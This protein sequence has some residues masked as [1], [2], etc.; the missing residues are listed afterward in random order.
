GPTLFL[1]GSPVLVSSVTGAPVVLGDPARITTTVGFEEA[2]G[3][4][5][6]A[7]GN[8]GNCTGLASGFAFTDAPVGCTGIASFPSQPFSDQN[9]TVYTGLPDQP[10][11]FF[12]IAGTSN[13]NV[14]TNFQFEFT[15]EI[16]TTETFSVLD[17]W[18]LLGTPQRDPGGGG[19]GGGGGQVPL[20]G[21]LALL[22]AGLL[23]AG[24]RTAGPS[25][26]GARPRRSRRA[27]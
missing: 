7:V 11:T 3:P 18:R 20:P 13:S 23:A 25:G 5:T 24:L 15:R 22:A 17:T 12:V 1:A 6:I 9:G 19:G 10:G 21:S 8:R 16:V 27:A 26:F 2:L 14:N 4:G